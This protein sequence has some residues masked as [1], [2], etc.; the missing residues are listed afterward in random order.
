MA[1]KQDM[2]DYIQTLEALNDQLLFTLKK[3]VG[4]MNSFKELAPN[5]GAN[6]LL[7]QYWVGLGVCRGVTRRAHR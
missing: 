4:V 5:R 7:R 1:N 2:L 6:G 3:C